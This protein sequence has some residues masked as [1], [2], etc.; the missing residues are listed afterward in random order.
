MEK[1]SNTETLDI[2][3]AELINAQL[4]SAETMDLVKKRISNGIDEALTNLFSWNGKAKKS[5]K[6]S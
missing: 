2:K 4:N 6:K 3:L 1:K 5:F